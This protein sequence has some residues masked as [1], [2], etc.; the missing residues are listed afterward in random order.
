MLIK[1][2]STDELSGCVCNR[3]T[4]GSCTAVIFLLPLDLTFYL[5][6]HLPDWY[7]TSLP[8]LFVGILPCIQYCSDGC[9]T[10]VYRHLG[11]SPGVSLVK[12][13]N[14]FCCSMPCS[15]V[16]N[17]AHQEGILEVTLEM[18]CLLDSRWPLPSLWTGITLSMII[19]RAQRCHGL[20]KKKKKYY[21]L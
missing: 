16:S 10:G 4:P 2:K 13:E 8:V 6:L 14:M 15:H 11:A 17:C 20:K 21:Y 1:T 3:S 7:L 19:S 9:R 18:S 5:V 12:G